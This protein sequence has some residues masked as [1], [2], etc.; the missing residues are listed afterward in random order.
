MRNLSRITLLG[1]LL[2]ICFGWLL[3][4]KGVGSVKA[5]SLDSQP[6]L[7]KI[8]YSDWIEAKKW[9]ASRVFDLPARSFEYRNAQLSPKKIEEGELFVYV[10][11]N[12]EIKTLPYTD[13]DQSLRFD[14]TIPSDYA[15]QFVAISM[16]EKPK[17]NK[18]YELRYVIIPKELPSKIKVDMRNYASV[19]EA[20]GLLE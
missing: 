4:C 5:I 14:Y 9:T 8:A 2:L 18:N 20:F 11:I 17:E 12:D 6:Y 1:L 3:N 16:N 13:T 15:L 7:Q 19:R 10:K